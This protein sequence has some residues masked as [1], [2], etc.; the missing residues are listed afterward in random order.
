MSKTKSLKL[1]ML[2]NSI[3]GMLSVFFPLISFPY[4]SKILGVNNVGKYNFAI[5]II[6]YFMLIA[7]LGIRTYAVR[8]GSRIRDSKEEFTKFANQMFSINLFSTFISYVLFVIVVLSIPYFKPY[9]AIL[10]ILSIQ[11]L[12]TTIGV[13][14]IYT[15]Y[16]DFSYIT[17]LSVISHFF[18][19]ILLF[20]CV[21]SPSDLNIYAGITVLAN[22]GTNL[23]N[24]IHCKNYCKLRLTTDIDWNKH[25]KP[26]MV[27]FAMQ[28]ATTIY[29][30][31]DTTILGF[32]S[33]DISVGVYS[34]STKIYSIIK[35]ILSSVIIVSIPRL[36][37][38]VGDDKKQQFNEVAEDIYST[39]LTLVVPAILGIII[40][41]K[42]IVLIVS[43]ES[44]L[45]ATSSLSLLCI[46][47]FSCL[48]AW[49]WGQC[50]LVPNEMENFVFKSTLISAIINLVLNFMLIPVWKENAAA[51]T[52]VISE[53]VAFF[54]QWHVGK[55]YVS[56]SGI[57][58]TFFKVLFGCAGIYVTSLLLAS[59]KQQMII[60]T[61]LVI[62]ASII[63][64]FIIE[65]TL[66]NQAVIDLINMIQRKTK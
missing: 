32:I 22:C 35:N 20:T 57:K 41:R 2:L 4:V 30:S 64:Y 31:S 65:V 53:T 42:E 43:N 29:I 6:N 59:F 10:I 51:F 19:L 17:L 47:L 54:M 52:T 60:Y 56:F 39:L 18:S 45:A 46:A 62:L 49:F 28:I 61:I 5:S 23:I 44:Y 66:K 58:F 12:F 7:A 3:K 38:L 15:I 27:L 40:L 9:H 14:W 37:S 1:N 63:V 48:C 34:V 24:Y 36:A 25:I 13:E 16:E 33:G 8:E 11:I 55:R 21:K 26:I 50:I